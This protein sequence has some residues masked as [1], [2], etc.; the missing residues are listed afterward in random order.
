VRPPWFSVAMPVAVQDSELG[1]LL[2]N[3]IVSLFPDQCCKCKLYADDLKLSTVLE[4]GAD[5]TAMHD[6][7][8]DICNW[9]RTWQLSILYTKCSIMYLGD[10]DTNADI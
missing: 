9:A 8:T 1:P 4:T 10:A 3:D 6:K 2:T 5:Y 7:I